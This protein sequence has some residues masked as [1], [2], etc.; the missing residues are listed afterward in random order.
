MHENPET[1]YE[2]FYID[3]ERKEAA[4]FLWQLLLRST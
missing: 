1:T 3:K 2:G 4:S